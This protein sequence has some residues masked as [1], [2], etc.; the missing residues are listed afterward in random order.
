MID[1]SFHN[2]RHK[3]AAIGGLL[4]VCLCLMQPG[5]SQAA[6]ASE[7]FADGNRLFR[8]ELYWAALLRYRQAEEAG[9]DTPL[10]HYNAGVAHYRAQQYNRA[11]ESLLKAAREPRLRAIAH[12][13]LGLNS[14]AANDTDDALHWL[15]L[16]RDQRDNKRVS[17]LATRAI[18]RLR[19]ESLEATPKLVSE[20]ADVEAR[21]LF[22]RDLSARISFGSD[23]NVFRSPS[24]SYVD[25]ADPNT[26]TV[27]PVVQ[28]GTFMPYDIR[29]RYSV[30][31]FKNESFYGAY[32]LAGRL[33]HDAAFNNANEYGHEFSFGSEYDRREKDRARR[34]Y[35][36]FKIAKHDE[37]YFDPD[38]GSPRL[39][40]S[41]EDISSRLSY[42]RYGPEFWF[43]QSFKQFAFGGKLKAQLW[44]YESVDAVPEY[45]F[46]YL[47]LGLNAQYLFTE[48]SLLRL[49]VNGYARRFGDRPSFELDGQQLLGNPPIEYQYLE[50][51]LTTRQRISKSFWVGFDFLRTQRE[52]TYLGYNNYVRD[53]YAA[54]FHWRPSG[55]FRLEAKAYYQVYDFENAFAF[56]NPVAGRKTLNAMDGSFFAAYEIAW[57]L[58]LVAQYNY[59]KVDSNDTRIAYDRSQYVLGIR[60]EY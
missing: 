30:N 33:Y 5:S 35:S 32:R 43:R 44:N 8:D 18:A 50:V 55:K 11:R 4:A 27:N 6:T 46:E 24:E 57:D 49:T 37:T 2:R 45:D 26:P 31:S 58:T 1:S 10:L 15:R 51:G 40:S 21:P 38:D 28:S 54:E 47:L 13:N 20:E 16:A 39:A 53:T 9:L 52:D 59:R 23:S 22:V 34:I 17:E 42:L 25:L 12:Y 41:G 19:R 7:L 48:Y 56:Q 3:T 36:A 60:W 14:Y 29:A